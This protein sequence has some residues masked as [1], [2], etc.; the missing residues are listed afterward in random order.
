LD[1]RIEIGQRYAKRVLDVGSGQER[2]RN[3]KL[4]EVGW[5]TLG[6]NLTL[7]EELLMPTFCKK[8]LKEPEVSSVM[9]TNKSTWV[10]DSKD[11]HP[12]IHLARE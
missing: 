3:Y 4:P 7:L 10:L 2:G 11:D 12:M 8:L 5:V 1:R 9:V 6:I